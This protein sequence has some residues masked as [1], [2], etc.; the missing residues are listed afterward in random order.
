ML[1]T[2][3]TPE[4]APKKTAIGTAIETTPEEPGT[5]NAKSTV[6]ATAPPAGRAT[7]RQAAIIYY[8]AFSFLDVKHKKKTAISGSSPV[9][10]P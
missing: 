5:P 4:E 7:K 1:S 2:K 6:K 8:K 10:N 9:V 3:A